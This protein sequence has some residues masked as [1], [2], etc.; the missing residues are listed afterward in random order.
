MLPTMVCATLGSEKHALDTQTKHG[1][2]DPNAFDS[3]TMRAKRCISQGTNC[4]MYA[5]TEMCKRLLKAVAIWNMKVYVPSLLP[6]VSVMKG[7][8]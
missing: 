6:R 4:T 1:V 5:V 3:F 7:C 8:I 2:I